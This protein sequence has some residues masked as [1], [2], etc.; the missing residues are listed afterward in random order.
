MHWS[1]LELMSFQ[2]KLVGSQ[3]ISADPRFRC[4]PPVQQPLVQFRLLRDAK[5]GCGEKAQPP[6]AT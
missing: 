5:D 2:P 3:G 6:L 1:L 4:A